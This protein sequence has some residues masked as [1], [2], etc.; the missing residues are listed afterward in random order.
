MISVTVHNK[1]ELKS[2]LGSSADEIVVEN[3]ELAKQLRAVKLLRK[4]GPLAIGVVVAAIPLIPFTG[5]ASLAVGLYGFVG[6]SAA[7]ATGGVVALLVAIG[8]VVLI[9]LLTD[10]EEVEIAGVFKLKRKR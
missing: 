9:G 5:G 2:A 6:A 8:G 3:Q 1:N 10:W 7:S 4:A